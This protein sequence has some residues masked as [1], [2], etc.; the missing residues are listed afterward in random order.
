MCKDNFHE[1]KIPDGIHSFILEESEWTRLSPGFPRN[2][3]VE[4]GPL[5]IMAVQLILTHRAKPI[6]SSGDISKTRGK[7][8][9]RG[10]N[11][12]ADLKFS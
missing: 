9:E 3:L 5:P 4:S 12:S 6:E 8:D 2:G 7:C 1:Q 10:Q 11:K